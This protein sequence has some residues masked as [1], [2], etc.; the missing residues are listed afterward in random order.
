[1]KKRPVDWQRARSHGQHFTADEIAII[2]D[3]FR[4]GRLTHEVA[5]ELQCAPRSVDARYA[6]L[7]G[8]DSSYADRRRKP[9]P[10]PKTHALGAAR[11]YKSDFVPR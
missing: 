9:Q 11:F 8:D 4:A 2:R 7:R 3:G 1:M 6:A 5:R 10:P